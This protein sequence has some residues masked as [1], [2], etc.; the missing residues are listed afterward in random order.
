MYYDQK[1]GA[2]INGPVV[3]FINNIVG[4]AMIEPEGYSEENIKK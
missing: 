3:Q 1:G 4:K 2:Y